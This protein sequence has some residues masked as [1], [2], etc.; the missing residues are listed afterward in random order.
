MMWM[1]EKMA[2]GVWEQNEMVLQLYYASRCIQRT[3]NLMHYDLIYI[4]QIWILNKIKVMV[5]YT[6]YAK[7]Q[8][9]IF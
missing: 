4:Y 7:A 8:N 6:V 2:G 1:D 9:K 3:L 5:F